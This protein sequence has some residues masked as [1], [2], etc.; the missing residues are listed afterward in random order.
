MP[1]PP[2]RPKS[3]GWRSAC[4]HPATGRLRA[5]HHCICGSV[6]SRAMSATFRSGRWPWFLAVLLG[7]CGSS[8]GNGGPDSG[9]PDAGGLVTPTAPGWEALR[10]MPSGVG[11]AAVAEADGK[12]Y[13]AGGYDTRRDFQIYDIATDT[14]TGG[15]PPPRG[16]GNPRAP[17]LQGKNWGFRGEGAPPRQ[18]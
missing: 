2:L 13:L 18:D 16:K 5:R 15:P 17:A 9:V 14:W 7:A 10:Q 12:I 6:C 3:T 4:L 11:E 8:G 1:K